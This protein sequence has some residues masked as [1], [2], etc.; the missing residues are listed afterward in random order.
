MKRSKQCLKVSPHHR[1]DGVYAPWGSMVGVTDRFSMS[2][3]K[4]VSLPAELRAMIRGHQ[5]ALRGS[6]AYVYARFSRP[7]FASER[8]SPSADALKGRSVHG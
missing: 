8:L 5:E 1:P 2:P 7:L 3:Q 6:Q 4:F